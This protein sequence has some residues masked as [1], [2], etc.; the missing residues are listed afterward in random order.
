MTGGAALSVVLVARGKGACSQ[1]CQVITGVGLA[2]AVAV[3]CCCRFCAAA[4]LDW[5]I[6]PP[7][8]D[9]LCG[10]L[11]NSFLCLQSTRTELQD[12]LIATEDLECCFKCCGYHM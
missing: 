9:E 2:A 8:G 12:F 1:Y 4:A 6:N 10:H 3:V 5:V 7:L 11:A